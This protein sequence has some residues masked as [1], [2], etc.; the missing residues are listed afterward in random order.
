MGKWTLMRATQALEHLSIHGITGPIAARVLDIARRMG[1]SAEPTDDGYLSVYYNHTDGYHIE[2]RISTE[3]HR[4][5]VAPSAKAGYSRTRTALNKPRT[6]P[7]NQKEIPMPAKR[8]AAAVAEPE[9]E[10]TEEGEKDYTVYAEKPITQTMV[11]FHQWLEDVVGVELD[12]RSVAL[13][14]TLRME[15]QKSDFNREQRA[16][17]Q[18]ERAASN[19]SATD[20]DSETPTPAP[21]RR[22]RGAKAAAAPKAPARRGRGK[23]ASAGAAPF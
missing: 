19:G 23:P 16:K 15:F 12:P 8:G 13:G 20:T 5:V 10:E 11:D 7:T 21:A 6:V 22:T 1:E 18:A 14:G 17:R 2:E 9:V 4:P 3:S